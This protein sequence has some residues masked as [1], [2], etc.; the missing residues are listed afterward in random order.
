[1]QFLI[2]IIVALGLMILGYLLAPKPPGPK[3]P[4]L[5]DF[6]SPTSEAGRPLP[7]VFGTVTITG[8]NAMWAGDRA[9]RARDARADGKK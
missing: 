9:I 7:V 1:M 8:A 5:E 6:K 4:E 3:R 2:Q